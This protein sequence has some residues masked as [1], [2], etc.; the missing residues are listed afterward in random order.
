MGVKNGG[1]DEVEKLA[2]FDFTMATQEFKL[3]YSFY[4]AS[5]F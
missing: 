5:Y 4:N 1:H 2:L 3:S